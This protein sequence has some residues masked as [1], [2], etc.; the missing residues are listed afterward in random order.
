MKNHWIIKCEKRN[1][2]GD[3]VIT[4]KVGMCK[5]THGEFVS[6]RATRCSHCLLFAVSKL[7]GFET[8]SG[9][10]LSLTHIRHRGRIS[11]LHMKL[12]S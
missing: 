6:R 5:N 8:L 2:N 12:L 3:L 4:S 10:T 7:I 9:V 1:K 11:N